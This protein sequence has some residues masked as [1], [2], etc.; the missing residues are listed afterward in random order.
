MLTASS[1]P[2]LIMIHY[3]MLLQLLLHRFVT[4]I[5]YRVLLLT[6]LLLLLLL[7]LSPAFVDIVVDLS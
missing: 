2:R 7:L 1:P 4:H 5:S 3:R 6:L